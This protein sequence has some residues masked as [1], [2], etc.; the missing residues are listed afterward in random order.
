MLKFSLSST[1]IA[2]GLMMSPESL[3]LLGNGMGTYGFVFPF[4]LM[5]AALF[6]M[7]I[8][9]RLG[10]ALASVP[11]RTGE[12]EIMELSLGSWP[13]VLL[14]TCARI[15]T[16][17]C[18]STAVLASAGFVFNEV[19]L[20][21]FP[22]FAFAFFLLG[23]LVLLNLLSP[24]TA[25]GL[26][27]LFVILALGGLAGLSCV[28]LATSSSTSVIQQ[29]G[30]GTYEWSIPFSAFIL[31]IGF[32][33]AGF[34][35]DG[36]SEPPSLLPASMVGGIF[37][38]ALVMCAWG[39]ASATVVPFS[40]LRET[41]IP[42][43]LAA[44]RIL[45]EEGRW[46]M[47]SVVLAGSCASVNALLLGGARMVAAMSERKLLP[48]FLGG[49][50]NRA[51]VPMVLI[52]AM[53]AL[54]LGLGLAG[55][56]QLEVYLRAGLLFWLVHYAAFL[57]SVLAAK[58]KASASPRNGPGSPMISLFAGFA[59]LVYASAV[60]GLAWTN[61]ERATLLGFMSAMGGSVTVLYG[62][63]CVVGKAI[64]ERKSNR[65]CSNSPEPSGSGGKNAQHEKEKEVCR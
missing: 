41:T 19:F 43:M 15:V 30:G 21:W 3:V 8:A 35:A 42:H 55:D 59:L 10:H 1:T 22:N 60:V 48:G 40:Q 51:A 52:G 34:G 50:A 27:I 4:A 58:T 11:P 20:Y 16:A 37:I 29:P 57:Y 47:G 54:V 31:F 23:F 12:I 38:A 45:S 44:R 7:A 26:Q 33:L 61:P 24:R 14:G 28:Q 65:G 56:P 63:G 39:L 49:G 6:H 25:K 36:K 18:L 5:A 9:N 62:V 53:I 2:M 17:V 32:E 46:I 13:V 64:R